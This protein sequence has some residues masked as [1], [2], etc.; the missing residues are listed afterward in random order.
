MS[1]EKSAGTACSR[2]GIIAE[3]AV[4]AA[5]IALV[6][7][8]S[9]RYATF[10]QRQTCQDW[11]KGKKKRSLLGQSYTGWWCLTFPMA[12]TIIGILSSSDWVF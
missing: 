1:L 5:V 12:A 2:L 8:G 9:K 3:K 4:V 7:I 6:F 10:W 11:E